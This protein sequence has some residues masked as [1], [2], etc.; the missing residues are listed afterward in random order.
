[1]VNESKISINL[2][3]ERQGLDSPVSCIRFYDEWGS[4]LIC[5]TENGLNYVSLVKDSRSFKW[6]QSS[7]RIKEVA[8]PYL[9]FNEWPFIVAVNEKTNLAESFSL[10]FKTKGSIFKM[11]DSGT[12]TVSTIF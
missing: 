12:I 2:L 11:G 5:G 1:M 7:D 6:N 3:K 10:D 8:F 9:K 4:N